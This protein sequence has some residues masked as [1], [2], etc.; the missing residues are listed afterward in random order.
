MSLSVAQDG[1]DE[2]AGDSQSFV[3]V[4]NTTT[5]AAGARSSTPRVSLCRGAEP[6]SSV[7]S[8]FLADLCLP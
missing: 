1:S 5:L 4:R 7:A 6:Y 8:T 2:A 3:V